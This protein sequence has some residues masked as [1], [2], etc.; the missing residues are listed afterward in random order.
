MWHWALYSSSAIRLPVPK[1]SCSTDESDVI[2][3]N[4]W[5]DSP[6][7]ASLSSPSTKAGVKNWYIPTSI[8]QTTQTG[9][10]YHICLKEMRM[11]FSHHKSWHKIKEI[12]PQ[13]VIT[14]KLPPATH[15]EG[16]C[17]FLL[18]KMESIQNDGSWRNM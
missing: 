2:M 1:K 11:N 14:Q 6:T 13:S 3:R 4:K 15:P 18:R 12:R 10:V 16:I 17:H 8:M 9:E 7:C 5:S